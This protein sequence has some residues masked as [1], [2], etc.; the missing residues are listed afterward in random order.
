MRKI[1]LFTISILILFLVTICSIESCKQKQKVVDYG[2]QKSDFIF[3]GESDSIDLINGEKDLKLM[4]DIKI[5]GLSA[6]RND[7][8]RK[9]HFRQAYQL[10]KEIKNLQKKSK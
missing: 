7:A 6:I 5:C 9:W 10:K 4:N 2:W 1:D 3:M 8:L